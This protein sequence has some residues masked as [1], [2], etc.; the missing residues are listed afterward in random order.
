MFRRKTP[1]SYPEYPK[2]EFVWRT[3]RARR[4]MKENGLDALMLT[5]NIH[6][7]YATGM[8]SV[9][10]C[11]PDHPY[12]QP[13][14]IITQDDVIL[15]RRGHPETDRIG[16]DT[17]WVENLEYIK[18]EIDLLEVLMKY[19]VGRGDRIGTELGPGMRNGITP[20]NLSIIRNRVWDKLSAQIVNGSTTIWKMRA[21]KSKLEIDRMQKSVEAT[22]RAMDRCLDILELGMNQLDLARKAAIFMLEEGAT[23][24]DNMQVYDPP[25]SGCMAL[26]RKIEDG[27][28]GLDLSA[29]YKYYIS[30]LYRI[31]LLNRE[32]TEKER[33]LYDCRAG[34]NQILEE[35]I[36]P[37]V[38]TDEVISK[39]KEYVKECRCVVGEG[40]GH[41]IG[42][43]AHE[44]P[45]LYPATLQPE[46]QNENGEVL[47]E[48]GMMF[49]LEPS[50]RLPGINWGFNCED[51]IVVTETGCN[52]MTSI[53]SR[54]LRVKP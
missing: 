37:G 20:F 7:Y 40:A 51:N 18:S 25:F 46:F 49:A 43:E 11:R 30:D 54:E 2:E 10:V 9:G 50:I 27:Y 29:I 53:L 44:R 17:C 23:M 1:P 34:V 15:S 31:A 24:V 33:K 36:K 52:N 42:L 28:I 19:G 45:G 14:V 38:S 32:P 48:E 13:T 41:G 21:V 16:I 47:I 12:P 4:I 3:E 6:V 22:A 39:M 26:D 5:Q 8:Q 35:V